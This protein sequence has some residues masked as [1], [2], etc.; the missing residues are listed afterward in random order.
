MSFL[1]AQI[2]DAFEKRKNDGC[3]RSNCDMMLD[4]EMEIKGIV[5]KVVKVVFRDL[6]TKFQNFLKIQFFNEFA[7][8]QIQSKTKRKRLKERLNRNKQQQQNTVTTTKPTPIEN[9]TA[10]IQKQHVLDPA[11]IMVSYQ[12][13][14]I[15]LLLY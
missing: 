11:Q 6:V 9:S 2:V 14:Y 10:Q 4:C 12:L 13:F 1:V 7:E 5:K 8:R 3:R 15:Y